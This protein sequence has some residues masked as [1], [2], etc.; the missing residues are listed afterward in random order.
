LLSA[1]FMLIV[2]GCAS[3]RER[4]HVRQ[5]LARTDRAKLVADTRQLWTQYRSEWSKEVPPAAWPSSLH[6]F[7]PEKVIVD[8]SGVFVCTY[9]LFVHD[10]GL[11][12]VVD[13]TFDPVGSTDPTF[14]PL[15][16]RFF[17]YDAPG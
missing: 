7:E 4:E 12:V 16:G 13:P 5:T 14:E 10:V 3:R 17:W 15:G 2:F 6:G 1:A 11:Y 8:R 9:S